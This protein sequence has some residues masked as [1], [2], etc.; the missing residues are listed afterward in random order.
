MKL[1][2]VVGAIA[3]SAVLAAGIDAQA[4]RFEEE[5]EVRLVDLE[6]HVTDQDGR[7]VSGLDARDFVL[8][9]DGS[10][11][12]ITNFSEVTGAELEGEATITPARRAGAANTL[13]PPRTLVLF[14]DQLPATPPQ[15]RELFTRLRDFVHEALHPGD[16]AMVV[17]WWNPAEVLVEL[18][19]DLERV[20]SALEDLASRSVPPEASH[21][22][23]AEQS[24]FEEAQA[25]LED[26]MNRGPRLPGSPPP[27]RITL[28][29]SDPQSAV[30]QMEISL[31]ACAQRY[32]QEMSWKT[33]AMR[34]LIASMSGIEGRKIFVYVASRFPANTA[35]YC[36]AS[37]RA[38]RLDQEPARFD[39]RPMINEVTAA[40][41]ASGVVFYAMRPIGQRSL[42]SAEERLATDNGQ[43]EA[44]GP[45]IELLNDS[46]ALGDL[47]EQTGGLLATGDAIFRA[48]PRIIEDL[49][50]HYS[51]AYRSPSGSAEGP[52]RIEIRIPGR[53]DLQVRHRRT[54]A[55]KSRETEVREMLI[56]NLFA[57]SRA[58]ELG[59]ELLAGSRIERDGETYLPVELKIP[60][61]ELSFKGEPAKAAFTVLV[62]AG[63]SLGVH[64]DLREDTR[65]IPRPAGSPTGS[66]V[67]YT[68]EVRVEEREQRISLGV[69]DRGSGSAAFHVIDQAGRA[70]IDRERL[71]PSWTAWRGQ[72]DALARSG[73]PILVYLRPA[74]CSEMGC[75]DF[76]TTSLAHPEVARRLESVAFSRWV[77]DHG[78]PP[79]VWPSR[80]P[81]LALL[82]Q[83]G[84]PIARWQNLPAP[85]SLAGTLDRIVSARR[86]IGRAGSL[87]GD[88]R[89]AEAILVTSWVAMHLGRG[90]EARPLLE[91]LATS[92]DGGTESEIAAV[93]LAFLDIAAG[94]SAAEARLRELA[95]EAASAEARTDAWLAVAAVR[96][97]AHDRLGRI[98]ALRRALD[99]APKNSRQWRAA[100][101]ALVALGALDHAGEPLRILRPVER[102]ISGPLAIEV[103]VFSEEIVALDFY[104]DGRGVAKA[105]RPAFRG[106]IDFGPLP[107]PRTVR[108]IGRNEEGDILGDASI[109]LNDWSDRASVAFI[110]PASGT[111]SG[112]ILVEIDATPAASG[113]IE[114]V[115]IL[116][117]PELVATL[118]KP[119]YRAMIEVGAEPIVLSARAH[120]SDG[121]I[122]EDTVLLNSQG[123]AAETMVHLV[124]VP[125]VL[126][127][128]V[129]VEPADLELEENGRARRIEA[130]IGATD[131]PLTVGVVIDN[132]ASMWTRHLDVQAAASEFLD[133]VLEPED[134]AFIVSFDSLA[135]MVQEPTAD[136]DVL[137]EKLRTFQP[138]GL[139]VM[140]DAMMLGLLQLQSVPGRRALV[141]FT[142][143]VDKGSRHD[144]DQVIA[145][146]RRSGVPVYLMRAV[147]EEMT[148]VPNAERYERERDESKLRTLIEGSGGRS[149]MLGDGDDLRSAWRSIAGDI[150]RQI[151]ITYLAEGSSGDPEWRTIEIRSRKEGLTLRGPG[152]V[153]I[154]AR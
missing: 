127:E 15:R 108:V 125:V 141:V 140:N 87:A 5:L 21:G 75:E 37:R 102:V 73:R 92:P 123:L 28:P 54:I 41:N 50:S 2:A 129:T 29:D 67:T 52:R 72:V 70:L 1:H 142:D 103:D 6:V 24:F 47:A 105:Q 3:L 76:E 11:R 95:E 135:R 69:F 115:E 146:A 62:A 46:R 80:Q 31:R 110:S 130:V 23:D 60:L 150:R 49:D 132:S 78:V 35:T 126:S 64:T 153:L 148:V 27:E 10:P 22:L 9:E 71:Q 68:L 43:V 98:E 94:D 137:Q 133:R 25:F 138:G 113:T 83:D 44:A 65:E 33:E 12:R 134:R 84:V 111:A 154:G 88:G 17:H 106:V 112:E 82:R 96:L 124:E 40:A 81:G 58:G 7:R 55:E 66:H 116:R 151:L 121:S 4:P 30:S 51:V 34:A 104:L 131:T 45:Q 61:D 59:V 74:E 8:L 18:T 93:R 107:E 57:Q 77:L 99:A 63:T 97:N 122:V 91:R 119:P 144:L 79:S 117:G 86:E 32:Q 114:R 128:P 90:T 36:Q 143:G 152:G 48:L 19:T 42:G 147:T 56:A 101:D 85:A 145:V 109:R 39:T 118:S 26:Q 20:T 139:T 120:G 89:D 149:F 136:H 38:A 13:R 14:I 53:P 100:R 16:R